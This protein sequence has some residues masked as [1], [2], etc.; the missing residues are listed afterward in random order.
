MSCVAGWL[1]VVAAL[2]VSF[3]VIS[4]KFF[5]FSSQA[6]VEL[7]GYMLAFGIAWG[8][9][10]ALTTRAH[11]R[12]DV[13]L[14]RLPVGARAYMH[15]LALAFLVFLGF[16]LVWRCWGVVGDAWLFGARDSSAL[17]TPLII[18]QGLWALGITIF[19]LLS[20]LMFLEVL[21]LL[22]LGRREQ[23]DRLLGPRTIEEETAEALEAAAMA[24]RS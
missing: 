19:F 9:T 23:I 16:F 17:A 5:G 10:D 7:T 2:F 12:V 24:G 15:A 4:R 3:D 22:V 20:V 21:L 18:P 14:T 8:L 11:I 6:T 1:F 13:L